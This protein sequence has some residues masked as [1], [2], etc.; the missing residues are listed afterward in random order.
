MKKEYTAPSAECFMIYEDGI[1]EWLD[2]SNGADASESDAKQGSWVIDDETPDATT[3]NESG[4]D[5]SM[6][7]QLFR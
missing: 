4:S 2:N 5:K 3:T 6:Q 1:C 7:G